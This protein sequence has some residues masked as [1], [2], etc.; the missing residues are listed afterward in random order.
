MFGRMNS[1]DLH[2]ALL[3]IRLNIENNATYCDSPAPLDMVRR[4]PFITPHAGSEAFTHTFAADF[5]S[6]QLEACGR[7]ADELRFPGPFEPIGQPRSRRHSQ[8]AI[9]VSSR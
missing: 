2:E 5:P 3:K 6:L 1:T 4:H 7:V 8:A 9:L